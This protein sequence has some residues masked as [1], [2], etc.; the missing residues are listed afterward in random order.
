MSRKA[1]GIGAAAIA[2][3]LIFIGWRLYRLYQNLTI[4]TGVD[5]LTMEK[6]KILIRTVS[7]LKNPTASALSIRPPFVQLFI[8]DTQIGTSNI[9]ADPKPIEIAALAETPVPNE[10]EIGALDAVMIAPQLF[11]KGAKIKIKTFVRF[12][13]FGL[14]SATQED[15]ID[16]PALTIPV[17]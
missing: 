7:R 5:S 14:F 3:I 12:G 16:V 2:A 1:V 10:L 8:N 15:I 4:I 11:K 9:P 17:N 6:G 13:P